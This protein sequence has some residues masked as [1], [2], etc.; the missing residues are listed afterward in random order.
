MT[1]ALLFTLHRILQST[2][3]YLD[4][5]VN[6]LIGFFFIQKGLDSMPC[7]L[8]VHPSERAH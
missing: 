5:K 6:T 3:A 7:R 1:A 4:S 2:R 8:S